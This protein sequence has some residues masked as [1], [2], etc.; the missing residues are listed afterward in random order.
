M[1]TNSELDKIDTNTDERISLACLVAAPVLAHLVSSASL[2]RAHV[3]CLF[4]PLA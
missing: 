1:D 4:S 3:V 2:G